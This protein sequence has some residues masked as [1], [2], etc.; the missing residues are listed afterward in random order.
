MNRSASLALLL[1][2]SLVTACHQ[3]TA[4]Q[5]SAGSARAPQR[6]IRIMLLLDSRY[7]PFRGVQTK[8]FTRLALNRPGV[9]VETVDCLG[10]SS[11][12]RQTI[13]K[14]SGVDFLLVFPVDLASI[15]EALGKV[16][17]AGT[18]VIVFNGDTPDGA[19]STAIFCNEDK[20]GRMAGE[21]IVDSL[22]KRAS[23]EGYDSVIGRIVHLE[24]ASRGSEFKRRQAAFVK[25]LAAE[26]GITLVHEAPVD[27]WGT[28]AAA[29][30]AEA[31]RL[32]KNFDVVF[33]DTDLIA[34][35]ASTAVTA[36][37]APARELML[38]VGADGALGKGGGV[39]LTIGSQIDAT[40]L[41]PPLVDAAW[42]I[43][44]KCLDNS[45][46]TPRPRYEQNLRPV[47]L[48]TALRLA[49]EGLPA[50]NV[51]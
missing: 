2:L 19:C 35:S 24:E 48:E 21:L 45:S 30:L 8:M 49:R 33:C 40:V 26:P 25:A 42:T 43:I 27:A 41:R 20:V 47:D 17:R 4:G 18:K 34:S 16:K 11:A 39:E 46:F 1:V 14:A 50:P 13:E 32:Q 5:D 12:Q 23:D 31:F 10:S 9:Q 6:I 44:E 7:E 3:D 51:E 29:R 22:R 38:I 36:A 15:T 28:Q 37:N